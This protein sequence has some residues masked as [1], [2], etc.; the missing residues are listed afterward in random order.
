MKLMRTSRGVPR[1]AAKV[2]RAAL[3]IAHER[4]QRFVDEHVLEAVIED[5]LVPV[6]A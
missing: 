4:D 1:Q 6:P 2:L 5:V 3:R